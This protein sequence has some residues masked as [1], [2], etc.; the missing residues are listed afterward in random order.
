MSTRTTAQKATSNS[1]L[2][3]TLASLTIVL[4]V[5]ASGCTSTWSRTDK[6]MA[7]SYIASHV[8]DYGQTNYAV[9][10]GY[11][12]GNPMLGSSPSAGK[13]LAVKGLTTAATLWMADRF[14]N[15][16]KLILGMGLGLQAGV[17]G[18][19]ARYV[20]FSFAWNS[21]GSTSSSGGAAG[22][23][24]VAPQPHGP[25]T[26]GPGIGLPGRGPDKTG[27]E[28]PFPTLRLTRSTLK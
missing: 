28:R 7:A 14:P 18:N 23:K 19:N 17:I 21:G 15:R 1:I 13:I 5:M 6:T 9:S 22:G 20:G 10:H 3:G 27:F 16:R 8:I 11:G 26:V 12:E 24:F 2:K 4:A 25:G